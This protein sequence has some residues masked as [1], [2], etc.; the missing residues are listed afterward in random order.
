MDFG[1]LWSVT[2]DSWLVGSVWIHSDEY[3]TLMRD[4]DILMG[5]YILDILVGKDILMW[6]QGVGTCKF[7]CFVVSLKL[8]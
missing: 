3:T 6:G 1:W 4:F 5:Q 8:L 2:V 7:H